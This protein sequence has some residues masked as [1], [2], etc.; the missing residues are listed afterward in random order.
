MAYNKPGTDITQ[1]ES[2]ATPVLNTP[3][4]EAVVLGQSF[5]VQEETEAAVTYTTAAPLDLDLSTVNADYSDVTGDEDLVVVDLLSFGTRLPLVKDTDYTIATLSGVSTITIASGIQNGG[6]DITNGAVFVS[7]RTA[8]ADGQGY[9]I[10]DGVDTIKTLYGDIK[11]WNTVAYGGFLAMAN[12][13]TVVNSYGMA[14]SADTDVVSA[15][16]FLVNKEV[17]A[18]GVLTQESNMSTTVGAVSSHVTTQSEPENRKERIAFVDKEITFTGTEYEETSTEKNTTAEEIRD[19]NAALGNKR[20]F[21][22]HPDIAYIEEK[23]HISTLSPAWITASF[24]DTTDKT[25]GTTPLLA[26]LKSNLTL[27]GKIYLKGT[28]ITS[29]IFDVMKDYYRTE[30]MTLTALVPVPGYYYCAS[31]VGSVI[32]KTP[33]APLTNVAQAGFYDAKGSTDYY[34]EANLNTMAEGGTFIMEQKAPNTL[35]SRHQLSTDTSTIASRELSITTQ[36]DYTAKFIRKALDPHIGKRTIDPA[37]LTLVETTIISVGFYL[38]RQGYI[39]DL[40]VVSVVQSEA[41]PDTLLVDVAVL[42]KYPANYIQIRL[43][44]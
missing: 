44:F 33:E 32:G 21:S 7:Y 34:S 15:L 23:R 18:L 9:N 5:W 39:S 24:T 37:F 2:V 38:K 26:I 13:G 8:N 36:L 17:Y 25:I 6:V 19:A 12:A 35:V 4:L 3:D 42:L 29:A 27:N 14:A 16:D 28:L 40:R 20:L 10:L 22:V 1:V 41:N 43:I 11:S 31:N 30:D